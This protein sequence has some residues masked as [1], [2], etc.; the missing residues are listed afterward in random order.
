[1]SVS[2]R[3]KGIFCIIAAAMFFS[4]MSA[5]VRLA[6]D[7]PVF[8]KAFFRNFVAA[9]IAAITLKRNH[10]PL[11][12]GK[13]NFKFVLARAILGTFGLVANF[14]AIDRLNLADA[15]MLNK[16]SP[17]FAIL[18]SA[19]LLREQVRPF[20]IFA[21]VGAFI[22][23]LCIIKPTGENLLLFP[24]LIGL[25]GGIAAGGA[26]TCL[27]RATQGGA[28]GPVIVLFFSC[29]S[30]IAVIPLVLADFVLPTPYQLC[31]LIGCG[32]CGAGGQF[33]ITTAYSYAPA[34]EIG[35]YDYSQVIF[36]A[37]IGFFLFGQTPDSLSVLGYVLIIT[38]AVLN[39][40]YN[41]KL[42]D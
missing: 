27:R 40:V 7:L 31:M 34:R 30:C 19:Y 16:L 3:I 42:H 15:N 35:V 29:F 33:S 21:V 22:G 32:L 8:E 11:H 25:L 24:A 26:Y 18:F 41:R 6:G 10:T 12:I 20:Q 13:G 2:N 14:Y 17:F 39:F 5:F 9:I 37:I 4:G 36:S 23:A 1:M 28:L 38:M